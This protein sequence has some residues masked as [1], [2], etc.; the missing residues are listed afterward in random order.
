M[1]D[2]KYEKILV[3][4]KNSSLPIFVLVLIG[5]LF[6][7]SLTA[8]KTVEISEGG[9]KVAQNI[10]LGIVTPATDKIFSLANDSVLILLIQT[11]MIAFLGTLIGALIAILF[12]FLGASNLTPKYVH[13]T[14]RY[15]LSIIWTIPALVYGLMVIKMTGTGP[16]AGVIT[17]SIVS[18]G[19]IAK[20]Y[21][22]DIEELSDG[23]KE[24]AQVAG[25]TWFKT[26]RLI[27]F[28]QVVNSIISTYIYRFEINLRDA[29]ILGLI[30]AGG[31]GTP[32]IL[33][34]SEQRWHDVGAYLLG[35]VILVLIVEF[36]STKIRIKL[37]RG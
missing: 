22:E 25:L 28:P 17:F 10:L 3:T 1:N 15:I 29:S 13:K 5:I 8:I 33:A 21:I 14:V 32:L 36:V 16:F 20:L 34:M 4:K 23:L 35:L 11:I 31:L 18:I 27:I 37:T 30:G 7:W 12:A 19:M 6:V 2:K 26:V 24:T 9:V